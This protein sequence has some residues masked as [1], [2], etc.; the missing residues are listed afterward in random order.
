MYLKNLENVRDIFSFEW[1]IRE[2]M[3]SIVSHQIISGNIKYQCINLKNQTVYHQESYNRE[4]FQDLV[5]KYVKNSDDRELIRFSK[6]GV[7]DGMN[8]PEPEYVSTSD[9]VYDSH[10]SES[11]SEDD[12]EGDEGN[13]LGKIQRIKG[14]TPLPNK[15]LFTV[16]Y[17]KGTKVLTS[18]QMKKYHIHLLAQYYEENIVFPE[19]KDKQRTKNKK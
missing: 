12:S 14:I 6:Y 13:C 3:K 8:L 4:Y 18:Q 5:K 1:L 7:K 2:I 17:T 9:K 10:S 16:E 11:Q 15:L 19:K